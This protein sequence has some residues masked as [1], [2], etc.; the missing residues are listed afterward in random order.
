MNCNNIV[1]SVMNAGYAGAAAL[2]P[3]ITSPLMES[4]KITDSNYAKPCFTFVTVTH[5]KQMRFAVL[6]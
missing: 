2:E 3:P 4:V 6:L 5:K 1:F